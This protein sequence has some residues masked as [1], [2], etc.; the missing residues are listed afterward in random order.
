MSGGP[1]TIYR[2]PAGCNGQTDTCPLT[3]GPYWTTPYINAW[4]RFKRK[5]PQ[6]TTPIRSIIAVAVTSCA[7]QT[8]EP[9]VPSTGPISKRT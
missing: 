1:I 4:R 9:F 2:N 5:S 7:E 6:S 8:D 3:V